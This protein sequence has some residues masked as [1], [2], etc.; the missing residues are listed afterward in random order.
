M[1]LIYIQL[2]SD[3]AKCVSLQY[4]RYH[5]CPQWINKILEKTIYSYAGGGFPIR[6]HTT[7]VAVWALLGIGFSNF[8]SNLKKLDTQDFFCFDIC[9]G[10]YTTNKKYHKITC[11]DFLEGVHY[12]TYL[13]VGH[14]KFDQNCTF[15]IPQLWIQFKKTGYARIFSFSHMFVFLGCFWIINH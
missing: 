9:L 10:I 11:L 6:G 7:G 12:G 1:L 14:E 4:W 2:Y 3:N 13:F 5:S 15:W 8:G